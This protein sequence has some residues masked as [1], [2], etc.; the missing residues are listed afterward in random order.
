[1]TKLLG[2]PPRLPRALTHRRHPAPRAEPVPILQTSSGKSVPFA[3]A[4]L[5][6]NASDAKIQLAAADLLQDH[7]LAQAI[8][9]QVEPRDIFRKC[10]DG[11]FGTD[12]TWLSYVEQSTGEIIN[13]HMGD[14]QNFDIRKGLYPRDHLV[15]K[16]TD[17]VPKTVCWSD[18]LYH[19]CPN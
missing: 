14:I 16:G 13:I 15:C 6:R 11:T 18:V 12:H 8:H 3:L 9:A 4:D 1:M 17:G 19:S 5:A 10:L 2:L 7:A